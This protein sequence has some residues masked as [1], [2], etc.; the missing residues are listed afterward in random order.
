MIISK[1]IVHEL[2]KEQGRAATSLIT[3][4]ELI[5]VDDESTELVNALLKSYQGDKILYAEF[6]NED[7]K[8]FPKR[9]ESYRLSQKKN[10]EF[11]DFSVD[12]VSN[13]ETIIKAKTLAKGGYLVFA[14]YQLND[15]EF[16][17]IFLI[18]DTEGKL[19]Q[20]VETSF[21]VKR[22][23]YLDTN[24]LAMACRVNESKLKSGESNYLSFI[25]Q[26]QQEVSEYFTDWISAKQLESSTEYTRS[27]YHII[28]DI[29]APIN[30]ETKKSY[31]IDEVRNMVYETARSNAQQSINLQSLGEQIYGDASVI[32]K[33]TEEKQISID[34]EFRYN[35]N[36]LKKFVQISVNRDGINLKF[37][38]S[39]SGIKVR[40][41]EENPDIVLIESA[42]F[43]AALKEQI[44]NHG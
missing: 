14:E 23:E 11:I 36:A 38:R 7:K 12:A 21:E 35:K 13:L 4:K 37:S 8:Y 28:N 33:Y 39:D 3:S 29:P 42:Q 6:D 43:A 40:L 1:I 9:F 31:S 19:L 5:P 20:R 24:H 41:S 18:R 34:T 10:Q 44:E 16:I 2:R 22:I 27:L 32:S 25:K 30:P 26:R 17:S 15:T